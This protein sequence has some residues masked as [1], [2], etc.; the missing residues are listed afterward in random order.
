MIPA[1]RPVEAV[2]GVRPD[3]IPLGEILEGQRPRVFKGMAADWPLVRQGRQSAGAAIACLKAHDA[4]RPVVGY[5]GPPEIDGRF[6]Y[7][8][9]L[10]RLNFRAERVGLSA[11]LD[12]MAEAMNTPDGPAL[13]I[14]STDIDTYLPGL[15]TEN[16]LAIPPEA[17][18][19]QPPL[20]SIWIGGRTTAA[21]HYD[22]SNNIACCVA[23][24]RRFT[25]FPPGQ[26]ANLY[27]G[28]LEPTPGGQVVSLVDLRDPDLER[29]PRFPE[30]AAAAQVAELEPGDVLVYPALWWHQVEA[31]EPFN[32]LVNYWWNDAPGFLDTP[33]LT[34]LHALLSLRDRP[35]HEKAGW[36]ALFDYYVFGPAEQAG[37]H[38]PE[39]ARGPLGP[40]D[41]MSARRLRAQLL[42]RLNR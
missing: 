3:E 40:M 30:A 21:A 41:E 26:A 6:G 33:Q 5:T 35:A 42:N 38:L 18:G 32:V 4:G 39:G 17:F 8:E 22:M 25:L 9:T 36:K 31:L 23:G 16:D 11:F 37:A 20:V 29:F 34:L 14:G 24:R 13:Y 19:P 7:D 12:R 1:A 15:R 27:P 2:S 10:T 28:P